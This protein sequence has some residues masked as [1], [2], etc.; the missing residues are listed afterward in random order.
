MKLS[1]VNGT[2]GQ[3]QSIWSGD[4]N[5]KIATFPGKSTLSDLY[6]YV[7]MYVYVYGY[8]YAYAYVSMCCVY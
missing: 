4:G 8:A 6:H 1:T 2:E 7:S 5:L 3:M